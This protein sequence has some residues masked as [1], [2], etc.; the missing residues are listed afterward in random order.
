MNVTKHTIEALEA[1]GIDKAMV[2]EQFKEMYMNWLRFYRANMR[3]FAGVCELENPEACGIPDECQEVE[4]VWNLW[5]QT[6]IEEDKIL[7]I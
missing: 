2:F 7:V 6:L 5:I 1:A 3:C 4:R